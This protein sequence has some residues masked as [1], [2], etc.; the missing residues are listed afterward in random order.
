MN[1]LC[2]YQYAGSRMAD[3]DS[4]QI[5]GFEELNGRTAAVISGSL[6]GVCGYEIKTDIYTGIMLELAENAYNGKNEHTYFT[7][8]EIDVPI[9]PVTFDPTGYEKQGY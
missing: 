9:A 3:F 7:S 8:L 5:T 2:P 4:W 1:Y 6:A